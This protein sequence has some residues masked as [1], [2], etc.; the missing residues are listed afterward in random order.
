MRRNR[1]GGGAALRA[2]RCAPL[3]G[4]ST[5]PVVKAAAGRVEISWIMEAKL[6]R[7]CA[8]AS[9]VSGFAGGPR[10]TRRKPR[11]SL[12]RGGPV[13]FEEA[14]VKVEQIA[15]VDEERVVRPEFVAR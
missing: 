9:T 3:V 2:A 11:P 7:T 4:A 1:A 10:L 13:A 14:R 8:Y 5:M 6:R 12:R 15:C